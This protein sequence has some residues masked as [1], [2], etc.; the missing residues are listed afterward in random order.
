[1]LK[2]I[3]TVAIRNF[4]VRCE[5]FHVRGKHTHTHSRRKDIISCF[6]NFM[7]SCK[8]FNLFAFY[9]SYDFYLFVTSYFALTFDNLQL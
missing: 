4:M 5:N 3:N 8:L 7:S 2:I 6:K 1:M 9:T